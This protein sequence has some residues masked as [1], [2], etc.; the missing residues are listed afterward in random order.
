M[1]QIKDIEAKGLVEILKKSFKTGDRFTAFSDLQNNEERV[2]LQAENRQLIR[3][4]SKQVYS[5]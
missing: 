3:K 1:C 5:L 2:S 4:F